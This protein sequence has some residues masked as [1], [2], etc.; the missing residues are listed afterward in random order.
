MNNAFTR[1]AEKVSPGCK[2]STLWTVD[3]PVV[4]EAIAELA[5]LSRDASELTRKSS[6]LKD[7][8]L[9]YADGRYLSHLADHGSE[10]PKPITLLDTRHQESVAYVVQDRSASA[11][12]D[13][14]QVKQIAELVGQDLAAELVIERVE[15]GFDAAVLE[16][17]APDGTGTVR[18]VLGVELHKLATRLRKRG[19]LSAQQADGFLVASRRRTLKPGT[20][21]RMPEFL[22]RSVEVLGEFLHSVGSVSSRYIKV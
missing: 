7:L 20:L 22:G 14:D 17:P 15:F 10:P 4:E 21:A 5:S 18:D 2:S 9:T 11:K 13:S 19:S 12:L 8:I 1:A 16:Q 3:D 6:E